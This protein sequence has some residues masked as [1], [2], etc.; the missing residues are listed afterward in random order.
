MICS[1]TA[2]FFLSISPTHT[3]TIPLQTL[4]S[5][6]AI[7]SITKIK[8]HPRVIS[9]LVKRGNPILFFNLGNPILSTC[10]SVEVQIQESHGSKYH[11]VYVYDR[12]GKHFRYIHKKV[13][14]GE[15]SGPAICWLW[16]NP[17]QS[18]WV[19]KPTKQKEWKWWKH[20]F[21]PLMVNCLMSWFVWAKDTSFSQTMQAININKKP[22][23]TAESHLNQVQHVVSG[24]CRTMISYYCKSFK[25]GS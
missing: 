13:K 21:L 20:T 5:S 16:P 1:E 14:Q 2:N 3:T 23:T 18:N 25:F 19:W 8:N 12:A 11:K 17:P 24:K 22:D 10:I 6:W 15:V 4:P 9:G 7:I